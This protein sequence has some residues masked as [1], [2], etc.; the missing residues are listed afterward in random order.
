MELID[1][2]VEVHAMIIEK[3]DLKDLFNLSRVLK[4]FFMLCNDNTR[5]ERKIVLSRKLVSFD[6]DLTGLMSGELT[7]LYE[8]LEEIIKPISNYRAFLFSIM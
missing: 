3:I 1:L 4:Y 8:G 5:Y 6:K 2:P 7:N